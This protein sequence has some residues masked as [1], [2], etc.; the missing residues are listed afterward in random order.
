MLSWA[1][2]A[3]LKTRA[4]RASEVSQLL[5]LSS[6]KRLDLKHH[7]HDV[8]KEDSQPTS[9]SCDHHWREG[10][11]EMPSLASCFALKINGK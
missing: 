4:S 11:E 2:F 3:S 5:R 1:R 8:K 7:N 6:K 10:E 9:M